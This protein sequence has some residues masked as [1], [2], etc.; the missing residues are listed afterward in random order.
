L[1]RSRIRCT[2]TLQQGVLKAYI[3]KHHDSWLEYARDLGLGEVDPILVSGID[4][5]RDWAMF[6]YSTSEDYGSMQF[7]VDVPTVASTWAGF[8]VTSRSHSGM[9]TNWG[10]EVEESYRL[11]GLGA[12]TSIEESVQTSNH[13]Y[14]SSEVSRY[15]ANHHH[16]DRITFI[17]GWR[18]KKR[19]YWFPAVIKA[20]AGSPNLDRNEDFDSEMTD[21]FVSD[22]PKV[23]HPFSNSN[24]LPM[25][26]AGSGSL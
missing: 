17:R 20:G 10:P 14:P 12:S 3:K 21:D 23:R 22:V 18:M 16:E 9:E 6:T 7:T 11:L 13:R 19:P 4:S 5:A 15:T 8:S 25:L 24:V 26:F 2:N 1:T